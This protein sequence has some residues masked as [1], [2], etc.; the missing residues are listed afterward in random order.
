MTS[1]NEQKITEAVEAAKRANSPEERDS[2]ERLAI[3]AFRQIALDT[4]LDR[5]LLGRAE[6]DGRAAS[7]IG[8][9]ALP[10]DMVENRDIGFHTGGRT[11]VWSAIAS[12]LNDLRLGL[13]RTGTGE[14]VINAAKAVS[15]GRNSWLLTPN[16]RP[17][18]AGDGEGK[19]AL[20]NSVV[21]WAAAYD[22]TSG[23][24]IRAA[25]HCAVTEY[26]PHAAALGMTLDPE[27]LRRRVNDAGD[28][29]RRSED[30]LCTHYRQMLKLMQRE[31]NREAIV[32]TDR[33][34][35]AMNATIRGKT[36]P[37]PK[38]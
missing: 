22:A 4:G 2:Q 28:G 20:H 15:E 16:P 26:G 3:T 12:F 9:C 5:M 29:R 8:D 10:E 23:C 33:K 37:C 30:K 1:V 11:F 17:G 38:D 36:S 25:L 14:A 27:T 7:Q 24:G 31:E 13:F 34:I 32:T 35:A 6:R 18:V 21:G 19:E